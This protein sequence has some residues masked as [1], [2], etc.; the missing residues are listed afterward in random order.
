MALSITAAA[1]TDRGLLRERNEDS[2]AIDPSLGCYLV[3]DGMGGHAAGDIAS[4]LAADSICSYLR[5]MPEGLDRRAGAPCDES[6]SP[7][8]SRLNSAIRYAN[9]VIHGE[10]LHRPACVGM[11]TT[12]VAVLIHDQVASIAHVGDSRL[13][14][15]RDRR[16]D[17]LTTDHTVEAER[18]RWNGADTRQTDDPRCT[19]PLTRA[20]GIADSVEVELSEAPLMPGDV[21]LL[22]S[23]GLTREVTTDAILQTVLDRQMPQPIAE[24][25][26]SLAKSAGG[27]DNITI[28]ALSVQTE[29]P[30]TVWDRI[31]RCFCHH[32]MSV[33]MNK[34][35]PNA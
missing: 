13:Y 7:V 2:Y 11:G 15:V 16:L 19:S 20:V 32:T 5:H 31:R 23:D 21:L 34:E 35:N 3:C 27:R 9:R 1:L 25:L 17:C 22:C 33:T 24:H 10:G 12:V 18:S 30:P 6:V 29:L 26:L 8:T 14:L 28:L 4:R